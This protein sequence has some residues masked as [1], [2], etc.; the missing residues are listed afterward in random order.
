MKKAAVLCVCPLITD[1][2]FACSTVYAQ[3]SGEKPKNFIT[4]KPLR[5]SVVPP[6][7]LSVKSV[8]C[9]KHF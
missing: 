4:F 9:G 8:L 7:I 5:W 3:S 2:L 1:G 6:L